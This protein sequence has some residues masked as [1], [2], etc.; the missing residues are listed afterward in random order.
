MGRL[1]NTAPGHFKKNFRPDNSLHRMLPDFDFSNQIHYFNVGHGPH[2]CWEDNVL[3]C[4]VSAG[5]G[6]RFRDA[7]RTLHIGDLIVARVNGAGYV[8][9]GR[10]VS[11]PVPARRFLVPA[12]ATDRAAHAKPLVQLGLKTNIRGNIDDDEMCEWMAGVDWLK[13]TTRKK[14]HWRSKYGLYAP[15]GVTCGSLADQSKTIKYLE[16]AFGVRLGDDLA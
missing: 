1:Y 9:V 15:R 3:Y 16:Q 4:Y 5:Q 13:T 7:I 12:C 8:G 11:D 10:V 14:A 6:K 2:R